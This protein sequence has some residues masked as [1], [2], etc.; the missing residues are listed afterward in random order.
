MN[1]NEF[2]DIGCRNDWTISEMPREYV[3]CC[4]AWHRVKSATAGRVRT[5]RCAIC[6]ISY[7]LKLDE[8]VK[9]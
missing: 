2:R 6:G 8:E 9:R 3:E 5:Y 7:T 4:R 1:G